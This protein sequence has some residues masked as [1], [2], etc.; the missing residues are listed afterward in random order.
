MADA[1][2]ERRE[3]E[4]GILRKDVEFIR[5]PEPML[6]DRQ[7]DAYYRLGGANLEI[8]SFLTVSRPISQ[9]VE[10][11]NRNGLT[12]TKE[13]VMKLIAF[14]Q[15]NNLLEPGYGVVAAKR[16]K[17][18]EMREKTAFLRF[19]S[20]YIFFKFP[21]IRPERFYRKIAPYVSWLCSAFLVRTLAVP[22]LIGYFLLI[23]NFGTVA[24]SFVASLSWAG[25]VKYFAAIVVMK[26]VHES[27]HSLSAMHFGCRVRGIGLGFMVFVPRFFTDTTDA[28]R[29]KRSQRL[30]I[31]GA[32]ILSELLVGGIAALL[33]TYAAP[34]AWK[35]TLFYLFAVSTISTIFVNGNPC[36]RYDGYY[37]LSDLV[38]IDNLMI[39]SG[40]YFKSWWRHVA[41][42]L[43]AKP[44]EERATFLFVFGVCTFIY[45]IFLYT[46]IILVIYHKFTKVLA[47]V[48]MVLELF[49]IL[50]YPMWREVNMVKALSK[51]EGIKAKMWFWLIAILGAAAMAM[52]PLNWSLRLSGEVTKA[53]RELI[54]IDEGGFLV[55]SELKTLPREV[56]KG[57]EIAHLEMPALDYAFRRLERTLRY[58]SLMK[59]FQA[60]DPE[61]FA[62][63]GVT[64][65]KIESDE[66]GINEFRR[67]RSLL[68]LK[69]STK[70]LFVPNYSKTLS[71]GAFLS[72]GLVLG[73]VLSGKTVVDAYA[74]DDDIGK[75]SVGDDAKIFIPGRVKGIPAQ[76]TEV[77]RLPAKLTDSPVLQSFGGPLPVV[78]DPAHPG[79]FKT[80]QS[81]YRVRLEAVI[82][83]AGNPLR[84]G[85]TCR[86]EI[87]HPER[88]VDIAQRSV[89]SVFRKE[90]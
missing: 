79:A 66:A 61:E 29:L 50:I 7:S 37:I 84:L 41:L 80:A 8:L 42:G 20:A 14:L 75:I 52:M 30:L 6:F 10:A 11:L 81:L 60:T 83:E 33:W 57:E 25:L 78:P 28:W 35:S 22:A 47:L 27:A 17:A 46:S 64:S 73:R 77:D 40:E 38:R 63:V 32:G 48:M 4:T 21:P 65:R 67:R 5:E 69:S 62:R 89:M 59:D 24:D 51:R 82:E 53:E 85:R 15:Q 13:E 58:D 87:G 90:F 72:K 55:E 12:V 74:Q 16:E 70:G 39:R 31:D 18:V 71:R 54:M 45:R 76:V 49:S 43:G 3:P 44:N 26:V 23:R 88:L 56:A 86:V 9:F 1:P 19:S 34:G 2:Q 36:I 68:T